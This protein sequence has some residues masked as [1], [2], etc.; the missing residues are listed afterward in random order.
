M[1]IGEDYL[2]IKIWRFFFR[3][4]HCMKEIT[5]KT[6]PKNAD[7]VCE[8]GESTTHLLP[9]STFCPTQCAN[10][11]GGWL[12]LVVVTGAYRNF[13]PWRQEAQAEQILKEIKEGEERGDTMRQLENRTIESKREMD[14]LDALEEIREMNNRNAGI[15]LDEV[16]DEHMS[17]GHS[18]LIKQDQEDEAAIAAAFGKGAGSGSGSGAASSDQSIE[19]PLEDEDDDDDYDS[20]VD[21]ISSKPSLFAS[22]S[23]NTESSASPSASSLLASSSLMPPPAP[24]LPSVVAVIV[25]KKKDKKQKKDKKNKDKDKPKKDKKRKHNNDTNN[26]NDNTNNTNTATPTTTNSNGDTNNE[27][28]LRPN[29]DDTSS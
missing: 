20:I 15:A 23:G 11:Q 4:P 13:E 19:L 3:C 6:D 7:Y 21:R 9:L 28:R 24:V 16:L 29:P 2:G 8:A 14:V 22:L 25:K 10:H 26:N 18:L 5:F 27:K 17:K 1:A 12:L